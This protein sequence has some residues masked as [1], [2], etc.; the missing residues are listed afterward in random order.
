LYAIRVGKLLHDG[1]RPITR[2]TSAAATELIRSAIVDG[3]FVPGE[4]LKEVELAQELGIS[5]TP[6]REAL[7]MLQSEGLVE[8]VPNRG[9][10]VRAYTPAEIE[11]L[12]ELRALLEGFAA[13][14][15]ATR[16]S[17]EGVRGLH[18][19]N[20]R[21]TRLCAGNDLADLI[22]ENQVFHNTIL[23]ASGSDRLV[24]M[25]RNVV[26]I[27]LVYKSFYW[28]PRE[29]KRISEHYH[30][31]LARALEAGD[32]ERAELIMK[33]HLFEARDFLKARME[34]SG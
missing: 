9:A 30:E 25:V 27:P 31:Q 15:A 22:R 21:F 5:R 32:A 13:R 7:L 33:E 26:E 19:S 11:E 29:Q 34:E 10:L 16:I 8:S 24:G 12:Y 28:Y 20:E 18:S 4:R 2:R 3:R 1:E 14:R 17:A 23:D 6:V